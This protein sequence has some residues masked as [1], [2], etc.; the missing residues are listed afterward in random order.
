MKKLTAIF[1]LFTLLLFTNLV[2]ADTNENDLLKERLISYFDKKVEFFTTGNQEN[3]KELKTFFSDNNKYCNYEIGRLTYLIKSC[4][5]SDTQIKNY[6]IN[7]EVLS[8][9]EDVENIVCEVAVNTTLQYD[10]MKEPFVDKIIH[11]ITLNNRDYRIIS[12]EYTDEFSDLFDKNTNFDMLIGNLES[13]Y[14]KDLTEDKKAQ[15][16]QEDTAPILRS[17]PGDYFDS[18]STSYRSNAVS[19]ALQY[20]D[21]N[22]GYESTNY[23]NAKF[24]Y[25][26]YKNDCQ[27]FVSQCIWYGFG[28]RSSSNRDYPMTNDWWADTSSTATTWNWTGTSYFY[29]WI[30]GNNSNTSNDYGISGYSAA[31]SVIKPGDYVYYDGTRGHVLFITSASDEDGDGTIE[32]AEIKISAHTS[33]RKNVY[34][35]SLYGATK[36]STIKLMHIVNMKWNNGL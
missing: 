35:S 11:K 24:K 21:N 18:Y 10:Y 36:P 17:V 16:V 4:D 34:L 1:T 23:N 29:N 28:G 19:Y 6:S 12:D 32:Y 20:T 14:L 13:N 9:Y 5:I 31:A 30:T 27:N 3:T 15:L 25:F 26:S 2:F 33:N 8:S 7:I 22:G